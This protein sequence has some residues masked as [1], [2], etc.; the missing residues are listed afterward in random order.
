M[1]TSLSL[2]EDS[3]PSLMSH[4][5]SVGG[6]NNEQFNGSTLKVTPN[7]FVRFSNQ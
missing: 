7:I 6:S 3:V 1:N 2:G 4:W 5:F